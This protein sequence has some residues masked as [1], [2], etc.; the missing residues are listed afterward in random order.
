MH[1]L[2]IEKK[3]VYI[4]IYILAWKNDIFDLDIYKKKAY[5]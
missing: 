4:K 2:K 1:F 5:W 3:I